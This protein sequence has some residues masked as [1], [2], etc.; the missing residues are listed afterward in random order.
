M[1]VNTDQGL[2]TPI[3]H[4]ADKRGLSDIANAVKVL[5][6]K[7]KAGKLSPPEFQGTDPHLIPP[8]SSCINL[9]IGGTFTISNLGMFGIK[10]FAAVINPPQAA[11][12]AV[13]GASQRLVPVEG[14]HAAG[15]GAETPTE[16]A[17]VLTVT[18]SCD[19]RVIDGAV[20]A[21]W[22]QAFKDVMENP[23]KL[24]L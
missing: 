21:E 23:I 17:N 24:L 8:L 15:A 19:H 14:K 13:G 9:F 18:L 11:I 5:A 4:N 22:L 7:A 10:H 2:Y 1:A 12:L 20:G 6:E 3:V 16:V